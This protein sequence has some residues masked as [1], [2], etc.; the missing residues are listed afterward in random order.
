MK[1]RL[2]NKIMNAVGTTRQSAYTEGQ[3]RRANARYSRTRSSREAEA[4]WNATM[5][6]IGVEGRAQIVA[7]WD[8][9][10]ALEILMEHDESEWAGDPA[11]L[12]CTAPQT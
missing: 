3:I 4:F 5:R 12:V 9:A 7:S 2:A 8:P 1:L 10:R 6:A 11:A